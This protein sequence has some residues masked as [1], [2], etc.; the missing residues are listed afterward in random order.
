MK[1]CGVVQ[2][3]GYNMKKKIIFYAVLCCVLAFFMGMFIFALNHHRT[4]MGIE[5]N[6][7]YRFT[8]V[9]TYKDGWQVVD[10]DTGFS[11]FIFSGGAG[12]IPLFDEDGHLYRANGWRDYGI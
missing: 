7:Y 5:K 1:T 11:Y 12:V 9:A 8:T 4:R 6:G 10:K 3:K 2:V